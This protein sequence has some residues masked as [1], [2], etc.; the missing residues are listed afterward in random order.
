L[1]QNECGGENPFKIEKSDFWKKNL[2]SIPPFRTDLPDPD[3]SSLIIILEANRRRLCCHW[4]PCAEKKQRCQM[5]Y[6]HTKNSNLD[7][8]WRV[9]DWI[10]QKYFTAICNI[11]RTFGIIYDH[12]VNIVFVWYVHFSSFGITYQEEIWQP[13]KGAIFLSRA[14]SARVRF[15]RDNYDYILIPFRL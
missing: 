11:L 1:G 3:D 5:V 12:L 9:L 14:V 2:K 13:W 10:M 7:K 15:C 4:N 6:F 8:F